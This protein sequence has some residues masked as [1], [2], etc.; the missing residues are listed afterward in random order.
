MNMNTDMRFWAMH[1]KPMTIQQIAQRVINIATE[2]TE[3]HSAATL[4]KVVH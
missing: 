1:D 3:Q 4:G 2:Q